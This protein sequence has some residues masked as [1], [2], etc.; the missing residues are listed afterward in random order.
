MCHCNTEDGSQP[1][2]DHTLMNGL[3]TA[4]AMQGTFQK[5]TVL[6]VFHLEQNIL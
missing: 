1:K 3:E 4:Q 5:H 6:S 2:R